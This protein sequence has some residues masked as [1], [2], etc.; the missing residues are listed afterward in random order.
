[1]A[2]GEQRIT[3]LDDYSIDMAPAD[4][5]L[6]TRHLDRP[7]TMGRI[8]LMLG[9]ADVNI[10]AMHLGRS[11]PRQEALMVLA[12]DDDV[13]EEVADAIRANEAVL[14]VWTIRLATDH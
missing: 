3:H 13:A 9:E 4:V 2:N 7:G 5:M 1:V 12:L 6:I 10:S 11:Q 14:D 8:G